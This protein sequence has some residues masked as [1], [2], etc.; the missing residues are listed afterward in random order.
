[1]IQKIQDIT[2]RQKDFDQINRVI[3]SLEIGIRAI[4]L[5]YDEHSDDKNSK[6]NIFRLKDNIYYRLSSAR[7]QYR[8]LLQEQI[9]AENDLLNLVRK[10][11]QALSGFFRT[12]PYFERIEIELSSI[13]DGMTYHI[14]SVLDYLSHIVCYICQRDKNKTFYWT[15][16]AKAAR[17]QGN[18]FNL[19]KIASVIDEVDRLFAAGLYDYRSRLIHHKRDKHFFMAN[20]VSNNRNFDIKIFSSNEALSKFKLIKNEYPDITYFTLPFLS[21]WLIMTSARQV[22]KLLEALTFEIKKN[23]HY[24]V[25]LHNPKTP[26]ELRL[27]SYN[28]ETKQMIPLSDTIWNEYKRVKL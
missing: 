1:M 23:S 4:S 26:N 13:F 8:L 24:N 15:R 7:L 20:R 17:G 9:R 21:S 3:E 11:P 6:E 18:E 14:S 16:L 22:D 25:N 27:M 12:N 10:D 2:D 28:S 5:M 19:L